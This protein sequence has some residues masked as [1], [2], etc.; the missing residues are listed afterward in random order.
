MSHGP[1]MLD[2][3]GLKLSSADRERLAHPA[4]GG[5]I[6]FAR[7]YESPEQVRALIE[8]IHKAGSTSLLIA[9][10]Q[11]GGRVQRFRHG[12]SALPAAHKF[13]DLYTRNHQKARQAAVEIGWLMAAELRTVGVDFSFAPVL[14]LETDISK[15]IGDRAF[16][17]KPGV[18]GEL[19]YAWSSGARE[20]GMPSVG[21]HF[22]GHGCVEADSHHELPVD[23]R[24]FSD[25]WGNDLIPFQ[26]LIN[27]GLEGL[28]PA[29]V[30]YSSCDSKPAGYSRFWIQDVLRKRL[31]YKGCIF[32]DDLSMAA[33]DVAGS[34]PERARAALEA[35]CDMVL[36]CN[37]QQAAEQV[38]DELKDYQDPV[39]Q[40]RL[41]R[42]HGR[43]HASMEQLRE[44]P[45]WHAALKI[46][47][48][49]NT[50]TSMELDLSS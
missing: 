15:V 32:S 36:V 38:L 48:D 47:N 20:A 1:L 10:D 22:P 13:G 6:L 26:H 29:H 37:N 14:D 49:L 46:I 5:I 21:K 7:N 11:E 30:I 25:I 18:I 16:S 35:G 4:A 45:R 19:A 12:F 24:E 43:G 17:A 39:A 40:S 33:A 34:Y 31:G 2:V 28:M 41:V 3:E 23:D 50:D 8:D 42:M 27:N 44:N 9:V